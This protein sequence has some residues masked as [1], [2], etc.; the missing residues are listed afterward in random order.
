MAKTHAQTQYLGCSVVNF[1]MNLGWG[2]SASSC[3]INLAQDYSS[4]WTHPEMGPIHN[5]LEVQNQKPGLTDDP[6]QTQSNVFGGDKLD[7]SDNSKSLFR[8]LTAKEKKRYEG[9]RQENVAGDPS[10]RDT[11]K[12][13]WN[14]IDGS[15]STAVPADWKDPDPGF[16]GNK[17]QYAGQADMDIVGCPTFF[18]FE[19]VWF[20]GI[21]KSWKYSDGTYSV[22]LSSPTELLKGCKMILSKYRGSV[23]TALQNTG[24]ALGG[25]LLAVPY[26][27]TSLDTYKN[28]PYQG[29]IPNLF[30]IFGWLEAAGFGNSGY[31]EEK[32]MPATLIYDALHTFL[33]GQVNDASANGSIKNFWETPTSISNTILANGNSATIYGPNHGQWSPY[34]AIVAKTPLRRDRGIFINPYTEN[35]VT[36]TTISGRPTQD[37]GKIFLTQMGLIKTVMSTDRLRRSLLRLDMSMVPRPPAGAYISDD[38]MDVV[39][40]IE[41]CCTNAGVDFTV[42]FY[43]DNAFSNFSGVI[44]IKTVTR[45]VQPLPNTIKNFIQNLGSSDQVVEYSFGEEFNDTKARSILIGGKQQRLYQANT[46]TVGQMKHRKIWEPALGQWVNA[47][48]MGPGTLNN[49]YR[50]TYREPDT[51][52]QR[53]FSDLGGQNY[54][55][56][57]G[58]VVAQQ[59]SKF[60]SHSDTGFNLSAFPRGSYFATTYPN[61]GSHTEGSYPLFKD[62]ISPYFGYGANGEP[63]NTYYDRN[64]RQMQVVI[65]F[66]DIASAFPTPYAS[67]M[68]SE[69]SPA[70]AHLISRYDKATNDLAG[71]FPLPGASLNVGYGKLMI[72][73]NEIRAAMTRPAGSTRNEFANKGEMAEWLLYTREKCLVGIGTAFSRLVYSYVSRNYNNS[74]ALGLLTG[75]SSNSLAQAINDHQYNVRSYLEVAGIPTPS[76]RRLYAFNSISPQTEAAG[77]VNI[78]KKLH[79]F[80][81]D[82]GNKYYGKTFGV[83]IPN[84]GSY[85]D[86]GKVNF[87]HEICDYAWE[88]PGNMIDNTMMV[89]TDVASFFQEGG[90]IGPILGFDNTGEKAFP[91][92]LLDHGPQLKF[93]SMLDMFGHTSLTSANHGLYSPIQTSAG[94]DTYYDIPNVAIVIGNVNQIGGMYTEGE[95]QSLQNLSS[96]PGL[97]GSTHGVSIPDY[98]QLKTYIKATVVAENPSNVFNPKIIYD[99]GAA[100]VVMSVPP[101]FIQGTASTNDTQDA[102]M[103]AVFARVPAAN[104]ILNNLGQEVPA[105]VGSNPFGAIS[106]PRLNVNGAGLAMNYYL[107]AVRN[108]NRPFQARA[109]VPT[110]AAIP[111]KY[112]LVTYGPWASHPGI[113]KNTVFPNMNKNNLNQ[114]MI[115]NLVGGVEVNIDESLVPW[116]FGGIDPLDTAALLR[117]SQNNEFQQVLEAGTITLAGVM[118]NNAR[119]GS[120]LLS[121][122]HAPIVTSVSVNIGEDINTRYELRTFSRKIGFY[123]KEAS[124]NIKF[125]NQKFIQ[126]NQQLRQAQKAAITKATYVANRLGGGY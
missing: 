4:H 40:F 124:D 3:T 1:N 63:R 15:S 101:T 11:G 83:R 82:L 77:L 61:L 123:N 68:N 53:A 2:S 104:P 75:Y 59:H 34:G 107:A 60:F 57:G 115:N 105:E 21:I 98:A 17:N 13:S 81:K 44:Q 89:G 114:A 27:D 49:S 85:F 93:E 28:T 103:A 92:G 9:L 10:V 112:N 46:N 23:S 29:N 54:K 66:Q 18:R 67:S 5:Q 52:I 43:P 121:G 109:A 126:A 38:S 56:N 26:N 35:Y 119:I 37:S 122:P 72:E 91:P 71:G 94:E 7:E 41:Y 51:T 31:T 24:G 73:E 69:W 48:F 20:G 39:S 16:I 14:T 90:K 117:V 88:E 106:L 108:R 25:P 84:V 58:A 30:N 33:S 76:H 96:D 120:A 74:I 95:R 42:E 110:F 19:D 8:N 97:S 55:Q 36:D 64:S 86:G 50:N 65:D 87:T 47:H 6:I 116:E 99:N 113:I 22:T 102:V 79:T 62:I 125:F 78:Q 111:I 45:R 100:K 12:K 80:L 32:G 70:Y 118:L